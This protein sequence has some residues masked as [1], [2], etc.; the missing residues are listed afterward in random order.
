M[1]SLT[2]RSV[3]GIDT[4]FSFSF[5]LNDDGRK[6]LRGRGARANF[7]TAITLRNHGLSGLPA[8]VDREGWPELDAAKVN[9]AEA[10]D[11][12]T[13]YDVGDITVKWLYGW[14]C[15]YV[16]PKDTAIQTKEAALQTP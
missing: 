5:T 14:R 8:G 4:S 1:A 9:V 3:F 6:C 15:S 11:A 13:H 7:Y 16:D 2:S 12:T 10:V